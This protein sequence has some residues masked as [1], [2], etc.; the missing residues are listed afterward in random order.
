MI[1][2]I[3]LFFR[4]HSSEKYLLVF[5]PDGEKHIFQLLDGQGWIGFK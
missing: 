2:K 1:N 4:L 5:V 3:G